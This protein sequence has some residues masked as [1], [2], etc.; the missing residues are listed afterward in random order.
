MLYL[1]AGGRAKQGNGLQVGRGVGP[2]AGELLGTR[3]LPCRVHKQ[4][5]PSPTSPCCVAGVDLAAIL[6]SAQPDG[7]EGAAVAAPT[8]GGGGGGRDGGGACA[9]AG[10][11]GGCLVVTLGRRHVAGPQQEGV[12]WAMATLHHFV[13]YHIKA[14]KVRRRERGTAGEYSAQHVSLHC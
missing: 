14:T 3:G 6:G 9:A 7:K 4:P 5:P 13:A 1:G 8:G 2:V 11:S 12:V 10:A